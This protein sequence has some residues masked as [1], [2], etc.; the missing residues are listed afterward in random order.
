M[1]TQLVDGLFAD[2]LPVLTFLRGYML[3]FIKLITSTSRELFEIVHANENAR[4]RHR[5]H[6][7]LYSIPSSS[8]KTI[9]LL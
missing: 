5:V 7:A 6:V 1:R 9:L 3:V 4:K 8:R 2:L